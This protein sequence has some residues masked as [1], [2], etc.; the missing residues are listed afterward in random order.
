MF[1]RCI[2]LFLSVISCT[3][4]AQTAKYMRLAT[5]EWPPYTSSV[6]PYGGMSNKVATEVAKTAGY[7]LLTASFDWTTTVDK[8]S[9]DPNFDGYFPAY[10]TDKR[11]QDC[12]LSQP[13]GAS[14]IS[15]ATLKSAPIKWTQL[16]E[17]SAYTLGVV[18]GYANGKEFDEL[19]AE[20][21][22][23]VQA[24]AS[25]AVNIHN[26]QTGKARAIVI[27]KYVLDYTLARQKG[28]NHVVVSGPPVA[29]L[30]LHVCFKRT[31]AGKAMRDAFDAALKSVDVPKVEMEYSMLTRNQWR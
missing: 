7:R 10:Y 20:K 19:V 15:V 25:D 9:N 6:L 29:S 24:V 27:D 14:V 2:A 28:D 8:G 12:Y 21:K 3:V 23:P 17:L 16:S 5:L 31:P 4:H 18:T 13:M 30:N 22:Q 26:L 1:I 11:N